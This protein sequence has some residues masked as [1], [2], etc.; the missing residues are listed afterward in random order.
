MHGPMNVKFMKFN[1]IAENL[2]NLSGLFGIQSLV[3]STL[4]EHMYF[5]VY[6]NYQLDALIII[7]L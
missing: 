4:H 1:F 6:I 2:F 3:H 5:C 7:Y